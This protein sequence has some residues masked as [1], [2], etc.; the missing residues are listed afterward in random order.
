[1]YQRQLVQA[2]VQADFSSGQAYHSTH[3]TC[4]FAHSV[5][6]SF[7]GVPRLRGGGFGRF[8]RRSLQ[9]RFLFWVFSGANRAIRGKITLPVSISGCLGGFQ[10]GIWRRLNLH[11]DSDM[12]PSHESAA[13]VIF[14]AMLRF[15]CDNAASAPTAPLDRLSCL[16]H[17]PRFGG[18]SEEEAER[19]ASVAA[20]PRSLRCHVTSLSV[21]T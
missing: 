14:T 15:L 5:R 8:R 12:A 1:M 4:N 21:L 9:S 20:L 6:G 7:A 11:G 2:Q 18:L 13:M 19:P 17:D 10:N 16:N 3:E